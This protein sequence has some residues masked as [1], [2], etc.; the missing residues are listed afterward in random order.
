ML[1]GAIEFI[2]QAQ[3]EPAP[4]GQPRGKGVTLFHSAVILRAV[5]PASLE[6][7]GVQLVVRS[8]SLLTLMVID[9]LGQVVVLAERVRREG[10]MQGWGMGAHNGTPMLGWVVFPP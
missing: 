10:T 4:S 1:Q 6:T 2:T 7:Q 8:L 3:E 5:T 9:H